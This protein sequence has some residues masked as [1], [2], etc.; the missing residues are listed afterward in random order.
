MTL[1]PY[2]LSLRI[3]KGAESYV[4]DDAGGDGELNPCLRGA[5]SDRRS[6]RKLPSRSG[7]S[8]DVDAVLDEQL[9]HRGR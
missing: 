3:R 1:P 4:V 7:Q 5:R 8:A 2:A 6:R 9:V